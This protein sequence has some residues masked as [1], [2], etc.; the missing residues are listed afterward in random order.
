MLTVLLARKSTLTGLMGSDVDE[1]NCRC[2]ITLIKGRMFLSMSFIEVTAVFEI[3][4]FVTHYTS[5]SNECLT[6]TWVECLWK[7]GAVDRNCCSRMFCSLVHIIELRKV[8]GFHFSGA[9]VVWGSVLVAT[10]ICM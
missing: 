7:R 10:S 8:C 4:N 6:H 3:C 1:L 9:S 2:S 5:H